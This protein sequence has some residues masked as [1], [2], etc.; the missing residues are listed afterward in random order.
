MAQSSGED[1]KGQRKGRNVP[2]GVHT[3]PLPPNSS[4]FIFASGPSITGGVVFNLERI[5]TVERQQAREKKYPLCKYVTR[6][7]SLG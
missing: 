1:G 6:Q 5:P 7:Q 2:N 3:P 4:I